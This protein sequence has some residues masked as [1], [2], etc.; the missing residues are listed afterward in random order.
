MTVEVTTSRWSYI[1]NGVTAAF[2]YDN[3]IFADTDLLVYVDGTLKTLTTHYTVSG[4]DDADGGEV[5]FLTPPAVDTEVVI[6]RDVPAKQLAA[7]ADGDAFP[8]EVVN[9]A[10]DKLM[11]VVQQA[12]ARVGRTLRQPDSDA[13][14]IDE[15]PAKADRA[16]MFAA[17]DADGNPIA[18]AGTSADL[19][20]VSGFMATLLDDP[21][22]A[23]ARATL[24]ITLA[25][26]GLTGGVLM[27]VQVFTASGTWNK[28]AGCTAVEVWVVGGGAGG[29]GSNISALGGGGG[30]AGGTSYK[31]ITAGLGATE[32]VTIGAAGAAGAAAGGDGNA[33]GTSSFGAHCSATGGGGGKGTAAT[34]LGG[35]GG[36]GSG[37]TL[38]MRGAPGTNGAADRGGMGGSSQFGGGGVGANNGA[39]NAAGN[40]G[41]GGAGGENDGTN[42]PGGAGSAGLVIV[43]EYK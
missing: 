19:E 42:Q 26:L 10:L 13:A 2:T 30:G 38:N 14:D 35:V 15:L 39:G 34:A 12:L 1:G 40:Y 7:L 9:A 5:T 27:G 6:V 16:S 41:S 24:E 23:T 29:G 4:V 18:A 17:Y 37:G 21:D 25:N 20:P 11:V 36:D 31:R 3:R 8:A 22:A 32:T 43:K 28:P 33:G